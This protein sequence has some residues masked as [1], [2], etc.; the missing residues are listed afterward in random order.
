MEKRRAK[1]NKETG[2][3]SSSVEHDRIDLIMGARLARQLGISPTTFW[4][5][6]KVEG[7]PKGRRIRNHVFFSQSAVLAWVDRQQ[8]TG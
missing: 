2:Q 8:S 1:K 6:R 5:W 3:V 4:R 7:F